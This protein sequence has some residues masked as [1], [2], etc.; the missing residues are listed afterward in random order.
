MATVSNQLRESVQ[1]LASTAR[2]QQE[3]LRRL[4]TTPSA[5]ELALEFSDALMVA[6]KDLSNEAN[7]SAIRLDEYLSEIS[8]AEHASLWTESALADSPEWRRVR[9]LAAALLRCLDEQQEG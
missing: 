3:Y 8:G 7:D 4:G 5:D 1:R 9:Q 6:K 2:E